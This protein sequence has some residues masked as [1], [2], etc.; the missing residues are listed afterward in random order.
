[1]KT[2]KKRGRR[3]WKAITYIVRLDH[4][5]HVLSQSECSKVKC[6]ERTNGRVAHLK[7][8]VLSK[9]MA[10]FLRMKHMV[11]VAGII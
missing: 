11:M 9:F 3:R 5:I 8:F 6:N 4:F 10:A 1:M 2:R 7:P